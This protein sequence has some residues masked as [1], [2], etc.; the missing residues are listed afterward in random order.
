MIQ[1]SQLPEQGHL[2]KCYSEG[3]STERIV[4]D[5]FS[6]SVN[7]NQFEDTLNLKFIL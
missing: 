3:P 4:V 6:K 2:L 5:R 7:F 1:V